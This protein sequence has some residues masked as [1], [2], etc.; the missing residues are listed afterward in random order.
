M[1]KGAWQATVHGGRK[2]LGMTEHAHTHTLLLRC[3]QS[4]F[5]P[6]RGQQGLT[7]SP[8]CWLAL[9]LLGFLPQVS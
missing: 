1:D 6:F 3:F 7:P 4:E 9:P 8:F 5:L 2:E